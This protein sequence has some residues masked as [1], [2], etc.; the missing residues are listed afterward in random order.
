MSVGHTG[1]SLTQEME[2]INSILKDSQ[3][4]RNNLMKQME[5]DHMK[6]TQ[7]VDVVD[8]HLTDDTTK[9]GSY[10]N[11][12]DTH[13]EDENYFS[14]SSKKHEDTDTLR[15]ETNVYNHMSQISWSSEQ[16]TPK[17]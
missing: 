10:K 16:S 12:V 9:K 11:S 14:F 2:E 7:S 5:M 8:V 3:N 1:K 13:H 15:P 4:A 17:T 6:L